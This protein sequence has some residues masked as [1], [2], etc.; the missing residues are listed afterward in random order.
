MKLQSL[1]VVV[2]YHVTILAFGHGLLKKFWPLVLGCV[3][4]TVGSSI[5]EIVP[6]SDEYL[7]IYARYFDRFR[8]FLTLV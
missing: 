1:N 5:I 3:L 2:V 7:S 4:R 6:G 8:S